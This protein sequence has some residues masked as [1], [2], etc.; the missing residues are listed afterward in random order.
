MLAVL[1]N[2]S[3]EYVDDPAHGHAAVGIWPKRRYT[4]RIPAQSALAR[5]GGWRAGGALIGYVSG[6]IEKASMRWL[7][8]RGDSPAEELALSLLSAYLIFFFANNIGNSSSD[9]FP[10]IVSWLQS[11]SAGLLITRFAYLFACQP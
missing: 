6:W 8:H 10:A 7:R 2:S 11:S 4:V 9:V 5:G 3:H 1:T